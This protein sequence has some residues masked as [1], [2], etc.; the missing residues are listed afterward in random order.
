[1][2]WQVG[3]WMFDAP[4]RPSWH[5]AS[6]IVIDVEAIAGR[7]EFDS[8]LQ[9]LIGELH[10]A[11]AAEGVERV[12]L[13]GEREWANCHRARAEGIMLPSDVTEKLE[14]AAELTGV[15]FP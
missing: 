3:S 13:P 12:L 8:R 10:S 4:S 6:F 5:N 15:S 1:M 2:T 11:P 7:E 9:R 14:Q